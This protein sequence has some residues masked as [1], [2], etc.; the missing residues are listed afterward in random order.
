MVFEIG[1]P[2]GPG[3]PKGSVPEIQILRAAIEETAKEKKKT[4]WKHA[5]EQA[6]KDNVL[7]NSLIKK[8]V[9]DLSHTEVSGDLKISL[10][11]LIGQAE[12]S[13]ELVDAEVVKE[14]QKQIDQ[15][16]SVVPTI[17]EKIKDKETIKTEKKKKTKKND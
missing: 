7:L 3:R 1:C 16:V 10:L 15:K 8:F 11:A 5:V 12:K 6:Y 4:L 17:F 13:R 9:P 2:G 14:E